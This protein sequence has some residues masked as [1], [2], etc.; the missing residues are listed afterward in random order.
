MV[1]N[2]SHSRERHDPSELNLQSTYGSSASGGSPTR[3][4][5]IKNNRKQI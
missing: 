4:N 5:H 1:K 2:R 3:L